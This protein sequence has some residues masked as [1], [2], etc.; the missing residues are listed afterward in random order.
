MVSLL[1]EDVL[2]LLL[3][4]IISQCNS[5]RS[6]VLELGGVSPGG[7]PLPFISSIPTPCHP[8][9]PQKRGSAPQKSLGFYIAVGEF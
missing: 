7:P 4:S 1:H 9:L 5:G 6:T 3:L 8:I 2:L